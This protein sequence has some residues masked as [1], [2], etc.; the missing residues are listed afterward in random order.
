M[1]SK[2]ANRR[3]TTIL[4]TD[5]VGYSRL[6]AADEEGTVTRLKVDRKELIIPKQEKY[7]G[8]TVKLMGDGA[9]MEFGSVVDAVNFAI[10]VQRANKK[11][12]ENIP[13]G[14][15]ISYRIGITIGDIIIDGEDIYGDGVNISARL[16]SICEPDCIYLTEDAFHQAENKVDVAFEALGKKNLKNI[17]APVSVYRVLLDSVGTGNTA[18]DNRKASSGVLR[19][20]ILAVIVAVSIAAALYS[21]QW[22]PLSDMVEGISII[23]SD[24]ESV[25]MLSEAKASIAVLPFNNMSGDPEQEYFS[26]GISEDII[27][28]LSRFSNLGVI[29]RNSSFTYRGT[30]VKVQQIGQELGVQY[31]LEGSVRKVGNRIRIN[32]QLIECKSGLHLWAERYDRELTDVFALQDEITGQIVSALSVQLDEDVKRNIGSNKTSNFA[33]YDLFLKG[34]QFPNAG[35]REGAAEVIDI[36]QRVIELDPNFARAYSALAVVLTRQ[37]T[38]GYTDFP[39]ETAERAVTLVKKAVSIDSESPQVQWSLGFVNMNRNQ[40]D[41]AIK[42]LEYAVSLSPSYADGY[43]LLALINNN[44]GHAEKAIS[45]VEKGMELNPYFS[46]DYLYNLGRAHYTLGDFSQAASFMEQALDRNPVVMQPK[47]FLAASYVQLSKLDDAEWLVTE[48]EMEHPEISLSHLQNVMAISDEALEH[49]FIEDL[50]TA[51]M[52]E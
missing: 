44:Q 47:Y 34:S 31:V 3:L 14:Q 49:R 4:M 11:R 5:V 35:T 6:M 2:E 10:D 24:T 29:A 8:R 41:Q 48:L 27:T 46:W 15:Q 1:I 42:A 16:E 20:A 19:A 18:I 32:A 9:L 17:P 30:S 25:A 52:S 39:A 37:I 51:G 50:R 45:Y 43:A 21:R 38:R 13:Q 12:N 28:D 23:E 7:H 40:F 26:D 36:F 33:A 22:Q